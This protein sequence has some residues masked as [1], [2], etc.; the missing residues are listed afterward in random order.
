MTVPVALAVVIMALGGFML[1]V[2]W[3]QARRWLGTET[4]R[5]VVHVGMGGIALT[6]P[7][8]F[9]HPR[10]VWALALIGIA[11]LAAVRWV[12]S[13]TQRFG[14]V[15][16]G[17]DRVSLGEMFFPLGVALA[18]TLA[19]GQAAAFCGATGVLAIGD[20]AG[21]LVGTR[22]GR[23]RY[24]IF[25]HAKTLEGSAAV[26][27]ASSAC[28]AVA[29]AELDPAAGPAVLGRAMLNGA[30]AALAEAVLPFG[31]DNFVL[32]VVVVLLMRH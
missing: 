17:V 25:G 6:F 21:A 15:L 9:P 11:I 18:F 27:L 28:I 26:W 22:W 23:R 8:I 12:P 31:L 4:G 32:P 16:G 5:K 13:L 1:G 24:V 2:R 29:F 10:P 20:T 19:R 3:L 7:W 14:Q 30:A